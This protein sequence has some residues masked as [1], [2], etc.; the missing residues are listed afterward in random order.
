MNQEEFY[1]YLA[2]IPKAE[3]HIHIEAVPTLNTIKAL[4]EKRF[5]KPMSDQDADNLFSYEDLN[6]F[7]QAF[8]KVQDLLISVDDFNYIF[9]DFCDYLVA[10]NIRYCEAFFA[11]SAFLKKG[12][13]YSEMVAVF[14][15]KIAQIKKE[16]QDGFLLNPNILAVTDFDMYKENKSLIISVKVKLQD[17][18]IL[19]EKTEAWN[20][21]G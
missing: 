18:Y 15:K 7:I 3:L 8:L 6:G 1:K 12:F 10:N 17:G 20:I 11:P 19:E 13:K 21:K 2:K 14:S 5:G 9:D 16:I 4:Y